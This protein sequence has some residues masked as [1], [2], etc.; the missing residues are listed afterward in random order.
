MDLHE[1]DRQFI[2]PTYDRSPLEITHG[3]G[4]FLYGKD[5]REYLDLI[6]GIGVNALGYAHPRIMNAVE[7]QM[8]RY[9]HLSNSFVQEPQVRLAEHLIE[10]SPGFDSVFFC[11]SGAEAIEGAIKLARKWG[12]RKGKS[13]LVGFSKGFHGRTTGALALMSTQKYRDGFGPFPEG[14]LHL[15]YNSPEALAESIDERTC[16]VFLEFLQGEG[17]IVP[18]SG[19]FVAELLRLRERYGF[20]IIADEIQSGIG[21]TGKMYSFEWTQCVP[22]V[23][24]IAKAVGG[25]LPLG[26]IVM[27][28]EL[29]GVYGAGRHGSTFGGNPVACA[30][31]I[32]VLDTIREERLMQRAQDLNAFMTQ[33]FAAAQ[34]R[35][36]ELIR[37]IRGR[38]LMI[39]IELASPIPG[40]REQFMQRGVLVN[41]TQEKVIR[42]LPPLVLGDDQASFACDVFDEVFAML[43][44][45]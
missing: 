15:P 27:K 39:G 25:G 21:R 24:C 28:S 33:R 4:C 26:A 17:G 20:L 35:Y 31:G 2:V 7:E 30:A 29:C 5:G 14:Y 10:L 3:N 6:A 13:T 32:A 18:A 22:D 1:L 44:S 9:M 38:G 37:E 43:S 12:T 19:E 34:R 36:P 23:V 8:R 42:L 16:A 41:I 45:L 11:N 40:L